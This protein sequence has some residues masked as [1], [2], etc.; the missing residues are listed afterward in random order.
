MKKI[1]FFCAAVCT[2]SASFGQINTISEFS[3]AMN[4]GFESF[5]NYSFGG[6]SDTL[7]VMGGSAEFRSVPQNSNQLYIYEPGTSAQWGLG[8]NGLAQVHTGA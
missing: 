6:P 2:A 5:N 4:E 3:G 7:D 8:D 1:V